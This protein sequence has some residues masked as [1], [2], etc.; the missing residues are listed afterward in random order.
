MKYLNCG[1]T[2]ELE[3]GKNYCPECGAVLWDRQFVNVARHYIRLVNPERWR[4]EAEKKAFR[5]PEGR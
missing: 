5:I 3:T 1:K 4:V 2:F